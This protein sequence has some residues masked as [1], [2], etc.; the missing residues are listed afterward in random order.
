GCG[1]AMV[2]NDTTRPRSAKHCRFC[3]NRYRASKPPML[4]AMMCT[5]P[6]GKRPL[7]CSASFGARS[8]TA[9][10]TGTFGKQRIGELCGKVPKII[11]S[12]NL[13]RKE[14]SASKNEVHSGSFV[15]ESRSKECVRTV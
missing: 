6:W 13:L 15:Y 10:A 11:R 8:F 4:C 2:D 14:E 9:P 7:I 12:D 3:A 5:S 1:V